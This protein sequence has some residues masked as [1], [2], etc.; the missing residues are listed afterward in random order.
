MKKGYLIAIG[1]PVAFVLWVTG[2]FWFEFYD[3]H[4]RYRLTLEVQDGN[5]IKTGSSVVEASYDIQPS[6][7]W[8]GPNTFVHVEGSEPVVDLGEKGLLLMSFAN[9]TRTPD[10]IRESNRQFF[11]A[12]SDMWCLPFAAY[13]KSGM[14]VDTLRDHR[15]IV[16]NQLLRE[17]GPRDV[18]F[19][20]LPELFRYRDFDDWRR[21]AR[22]STSNLAMS[23]GPGVELKRVILE[24]TNDP[25]TSASEP[26]RQWLKKNGII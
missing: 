4:V 1:I 21:T 2:L 17:S 10:Q 23:F 11:C 18:P 26:L 15:K 13:G 6:W 14:G 24:L 20:I 19:G 8:S 3:V 12:M 7:S 16:V 9:A 22:V 25:I 5:Q